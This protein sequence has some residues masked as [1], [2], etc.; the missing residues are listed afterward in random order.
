MAESRIEQLNKAI[1][2]GIAAVEEEEFLKGLNLLAEGYSGQ[3]ESVLPD[4]L[5]YYGLALALVQ[6]KFK[7]AI[8]LCRKAIELQFYNPSHYANLARVYVAAGNRK[9]AVEAIEQG[10]KIFPDDDV[11]IA[12]RRE[13]GIR[14][15]PAVPFLSRQ[16]ALNKVLGRTRHARKSDSPLPKE[17]K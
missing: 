13:L 7:P 2:A 14:S 10:F 1:Q 12:V 8:D 16:N 3:V 4:G 9:R 11:L 17:R 5:S 6:K 15:R